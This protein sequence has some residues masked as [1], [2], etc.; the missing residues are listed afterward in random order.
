MCR[1]VRSRRPVWWRTLSTVT[2]SARTTNGGPRRPVSPGHVFTT[3]IKARGDRGDIYRLRAHAEIWHSFQCRVRGVLPVRLERVRELPITPIDYTAEGADSAAVIASPSGAIR[4]HRFNSIL[5]SEI[6]SHNIQAYMTTEI[7]N[8]L[9]SELVPIVAGFLLTTVLWG[10]L[11]FLF[12]SRSWNHQHRVQITEQERKTAVALFEEISRLM[13][14]RLYPTRY[15]FS[16]WI[17][18]K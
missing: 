13:D 4:K 6:L 7:R 8:N 2:A 10:T 18:L 17:F 1:G 14:R 9:W 3:P 12:Q 5:S 15:T 11:G 16:T